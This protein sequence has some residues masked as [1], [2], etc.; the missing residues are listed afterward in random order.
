VNDSGM[1]ELSF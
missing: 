1:T